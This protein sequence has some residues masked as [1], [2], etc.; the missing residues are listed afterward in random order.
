MERANKKNIESRFRKLIYGTLDGEV[1]TLDQENG[2]EIWR[3]QASSEILSSPIT[4]GSVVIAQGSNG[5]VTGFDFKN[6]TKKWVHQ[7]SVPS[8]S[9]RGTATPI[10]K[11]GFVFTGFANGKVAMIYP[12]SGAI[13]LEL[14]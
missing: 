5:S 8:L 12:D 9:L 6:G 7:A 1:V 14:P 11:L 4:D 2:S 3:S 10:L 13:R